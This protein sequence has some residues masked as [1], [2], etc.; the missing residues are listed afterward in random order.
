MKSSGERFLSWFAQPIGEILPP[1]RNQRNAR[2]LRLVRVLDRNDFRPLGEQDKR[3]AALLAAEEVEIVVDLR[4]PNPALSLD[5]T[6]VSEPFARMR[7]SGRLPLG[8]TNCVSTSTS[9]DPCRAQANPATVQVPRGP[10]AGGTRASRWEL[11]FVTL[12][13]AS[14][15]QED[16]LPLRRHQVVT[17]LRRLR[18]L[19]G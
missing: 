3:S 2:A 11:V 9:L 10:P 15:D 5:S 19:P 8:I 4:F 18:G 1:G 7:M 12:V 6:K 13:P 17:G 14:A 16:V